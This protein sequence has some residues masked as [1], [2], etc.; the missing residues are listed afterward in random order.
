MADLMVPSR[1]CVLF[2]SLG[3]TSGYSGTVSIPLR[4]GGSRCFVDVVILV[5][6]A[7]AAS[8]A[9]TAAGR[10][11]EELAAELAAECTIGKLGTER[12]DSGGADCMGLRKLLARALRRTLS[13]LAA[14]AAPTTL[15]ELFA[16]KML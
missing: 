15:A 5:A 9:A 16:V 12:V 2:S 6:A 10:F 7:A 1:W 14:P 8:A 3:K 13:F 11:V 4:G